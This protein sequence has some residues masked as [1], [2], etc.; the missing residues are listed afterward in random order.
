[1][2]S[3]VPLRNRQQNILKP[4][5]YPKPVYAFIAGQ[6][7]P[8]GKRMGHAGAIVEKGSGTVESKIETLR[9]AG[10]KRSKQV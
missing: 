2:K 4:P 8:Q 1:V 6:N 7:A 5:S 10:R 3:E 9:Q